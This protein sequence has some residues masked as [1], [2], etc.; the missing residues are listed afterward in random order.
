MSKYTGRQQSAISRNAD[1]SN[2]ENY[3]LKEFEDKLIQKDAVQTKSVDSSLFDQINSI[4]N[5]K[6]KHNSV[7]SAVEDM[8]ERSGLNTFLQKKQSSEEQSTKIAQ[9]E[10]KAS[11][12]QNDAKKPQEKKMPILL[13]KCP[14]IKNTFD[15]IVKSTR[16]NLSIPAI[17]DRVK[18][19]HQNDV[20]DAK[21]WD[22]ND[23]IR[24][25]SRLNLE[26][27]SKNNQ[28]NDSMN[29][30]IMDNSINGDIDKENNDAFI[31]LMPAKF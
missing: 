24:F 4:M 6:S 9:Q 23:I 16:G 20:S 22:S 12:D 2:D 26:E 27:K 10:K 28:H 21:D 14:N 29:L 13:V 31:G 3:W 19:I 15:N 30:G 5:G 25:V 17:I 1:E 7:A 11:D 18:S 8:K